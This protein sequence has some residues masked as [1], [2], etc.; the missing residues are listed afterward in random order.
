MVRKTGFAILMVIVALAGIIILPQTA[1]AISLKQ[2][3]VVSGDTIT[4]GDVFQCLP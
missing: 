2:N 3:S 4:L 1:R